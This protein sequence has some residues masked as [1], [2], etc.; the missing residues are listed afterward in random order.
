MAATTRMSQRSGLESPTL[1]TTRSCNARSSFTCS[2]TGI[3]PISSRNSVPLSACWNLPW[4]VATAPVKA[5]RT[6]PNSS[7]SIRFSGMAPQ[8]TTTKGPLLRGLRA[9]ISL[10]ISSLPV[11]VSPV[12]NTLMSVVATFS[13]LWNTSTTPG[14]LP[15]M[16][17]KCLCSSFSCK[18]SRSLFS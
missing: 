8:L 7:D 5:P 3:S 17:P 9:W 10:A 4:R 6:C 16:S 2:V 11:P 14:Q 12:I 18:R 13:T 15:T 1:I